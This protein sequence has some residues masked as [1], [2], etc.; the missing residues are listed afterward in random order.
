MSP[1]FDQIDLLELAAIEAG[2]TFDGSDEL[3][4]MSKWFDLKLKSIYTK[5]D[6]L[7]TFRI[8]GSDDLVPTDVSNSGYDYAYTL[9][10]DVVGIPTPN[11]SSTS[12]YSLDYN[13]R[14]NLPFDVRQYRGGSS[15]FD[16]G[17]VD[18]VLRGNVLYT[19]AEVN[20]IVAKVYVDIS[21]TPA[22]FQE[23]MSLYAGSVLL[24]RQAD[25]RS[26]TRYNRAKSLE[27]AVISR[28]K[29]PQNELQKIIQNYLGQTYSIIGTV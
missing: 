2:V 12:L 4:G 26:L 20:C 21:D 23:M 14:N 8:L 11:G 7:W 24:E 10:K 28:G 5:N 29:E 19:N 13:I 16:T 15:I 25:P 27:A 1:K 3:A 6:F 22:D 18:F 9:P 17:S